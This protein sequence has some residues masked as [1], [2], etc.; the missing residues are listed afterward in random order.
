MFNEKEV[1]KTPKTKSMKKLKIPVQGKG[2]RR[3]MNQGSIKN[4]LHEHYVKCDALPNFS[5]RAICK[6]NFF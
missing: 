1:M 3:S 4:S 5:A 2:V 6:V